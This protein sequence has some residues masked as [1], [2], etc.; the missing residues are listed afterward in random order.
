MTVVISVTESGAA[1]ARRLPYEHRHG[2]LA[3]TV[4]SVWDSV[5]RLVLVC[6]TGIA[7]RVLA[8]LLTDKHDDPAVVCL[9]DAGRWAIALTGGHHG[10]NA[11]ARE[12]ATLVGAEPV[13]TTATDAAGL[14]ALDDLPGFHTTGDV[15]AVTRTWLDGTAPTLD[16]TDLPHWPLPAAL[17]ALGSGPAI[18]VTDRVV[19]PAAGEVL[20]R[21]CSLV[22][23]VGSSSGAA[24]D[25]ISD[26]LSK[27]L[28]DT[29][30]DPAGIGLI[31]S[32]DLKQDE[33]GIVALAAE[34]GVELRTFPATA[35][36]EVEVPT[37]SPVVAAAVGTPS[38]AE[39]AALLAA[40][41]G[42][43]LV[44]DKQRSSEATVAVARRAHPE[45]H[46][47]VV[48]LGPGDPAW[49]TPAAAT[50]IRKA[51][52]VIGYGLYIDLAADLLEPRHEVVRS[53][54]GAETDRCRES[55]ERA[56]A[57]EQVALV[58][59]G[60]PGVFAMASLVCELAP[61]VGNPPMTV[62]PGVTAAYGAAAVLGAPLGHDH[63]MVSLSD[64]L[65]PWPLIERRLVAVA[66]GDLAVSFYNPRSQRRTWQL[67]RAIEIL[68][69]HR[70]ADCPVAIVSDVGRAERQR[71]V[72]TT[73]S[74]IDPAAVDMLSLVV[75]GS[76]TTRWQGDVMVTPRGY[77]AA[78]AATT[79]EAS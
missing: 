42:A 20:L 13:V 43:E 79:A 78:A 68:A 21:P 51:D 74:T 50:A 26:L 30:F 37:P 41:P 69:E 34:H 48:G 24:V 66:E 46:L 65:T 23:G 29:G 36:A 71:V 8:P 3:D 70:P 59:S 58:C 54:I 6:A 31:A 52:V 25:G 16:R 61:G 35:L 5:D 33:P 75:V 17:S 39:A 76:S 14:P 11:L 19:E 22:I 28:A 44:V 12:V 18:R 40:G 1:L 47:A 49:R 72:R 55:L 10:A 9:D 15:A 73:L 57:G 38:V 27:A 4:R 7:V 67:G 62:V 53:P 63:A 77:P 64:L 32:V 56:A 45:G 60:D 2:A